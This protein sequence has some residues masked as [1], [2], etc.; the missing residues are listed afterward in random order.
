M[1]EMGHKTSA[2]RSGKYAGRTPQT[3][4]FDPCHLLSKP[5]LV[6]TLCTTP[7]PNGAQ[8][9]TLAVSECRVYLNGSLRWATH[10][11]ISM[12]RY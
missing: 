11:Q 8:F 3:P 6:F 1:R 12:Q 2:A 5:L 10:R 9:A 7:D 4:N